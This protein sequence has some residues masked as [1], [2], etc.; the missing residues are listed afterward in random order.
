MSLVPPSLLPTPW[1]DVNF[2]NI[3]TLKLLK[4]VAPIVELIVAE[5]SSKQYDNLI[6]FTDFCKQ[7]GKELSDQDKMRCFVYSSS[8]KKP[9]YTDDRSYRGLK[10]FMLR[11][12][13]RSNRQKAVNHE[14]NF[15]KRQ[16]C[17]SAARSRRN[18]R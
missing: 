14:H 4:S 2:C 11:L 8:N 16:C 9:S 17:R 18:R 3:S 6:M 13:S 7:K 15:P 10:D 12:G 5:R 1:V